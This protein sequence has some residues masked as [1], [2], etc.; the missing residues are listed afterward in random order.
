MFLCVN[1]GFDKYVCEWR[2]GI[3]DIDALVERNQ[4]APNKAIDSGRIPIVVFLDGNRVRI[5]RCVVCHLLVK[6]VRCVRLFDLFPGPS[7]PESQWPNWQDSEERS[8][9]S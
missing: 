7:R 3:T 8:C 9:S 4:E 5:N 2:S 6:V 1:V